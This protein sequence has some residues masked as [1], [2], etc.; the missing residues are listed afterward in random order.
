MCSSENRG[1]TAAIALDKHVNGLILNQ[2]GRREQKKAHQRRKEGKYGRED[3]AVVKR[4]SSERHQ[5]AAKTRT[6][7]QHERK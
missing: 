3:K 5:I 7:R 2:Q 1:N 6:G 4:K